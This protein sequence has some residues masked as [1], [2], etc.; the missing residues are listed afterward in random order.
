MRPGFGR[1]SFQDAAP[2]SL[3]DFFARPDVVLASPAEG[4]VSA[5]GQ[6]TSGVDTHLEKVNRVEVQLREHVRQNC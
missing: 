6:A 3:V 4:F 2:R 5:G 1:T